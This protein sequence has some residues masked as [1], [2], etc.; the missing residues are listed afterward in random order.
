MHEPEGP[1]GEHGAIAGVEGL[2][3]RGDQP[4]HVAEDEEG[5]D[6]ER[7]AGETVFLAAHQR[8]GA[9]AGRDVV[10][11]KE[12]KIVSV[13]LITRPTVSSLVKLKTVLYLS[14]SWT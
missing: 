3:G 8:A 7:D 11:K 2:V 12:S 4:P 13:Q 6:G 14:L 9:P 1:L 10:W 5:D